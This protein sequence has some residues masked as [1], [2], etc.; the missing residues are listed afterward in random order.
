ML[1]NSAHRMSHPNCQ[2]SNLTMESI[3]M[4]KSAQCTWR[5]GFVC[6]FCLFLESVNLSHC[7]LPFYF[8]EKLVFL[9]GGSD[10]LGLTVTEDSKR[11]TDPS[12]SPRQTDC[13]WACE[14]NWSLGTGIRHTINR[15]DR[16][17]HRKLTVGLFHPPCGIVFSSQSTPRSPRPQDFKRPK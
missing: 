6:C 3:H 7:W 11:T 16:A 5:D 8:K 15:K 13:R 9:G 14:H 4:A 12:Q 1:S 2:L 10:L 17:L